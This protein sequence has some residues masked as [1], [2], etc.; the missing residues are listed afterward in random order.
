MQI[1]LEVSPENIANLLCSAFEGG[2]GYWCRIMHDVEPE[3]AVENNLLKDFP[4]YCSYPLQGGAV[5]CR[6]D[7]DEETDEKYTP[8]TLNGEAIK[9]GLEILASKY[10][11]HFADF[12]KDNY[13]ASTGDAF[14][15]CCLLGG[16]EYW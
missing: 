12:M 11:Q 1:N 10:P 4:Y 6:R 13:D 7:D 15:Q 16:C 14:V 5:V 2:V 8:L 9:R 3:E